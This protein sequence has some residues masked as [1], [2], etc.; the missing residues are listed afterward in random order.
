MAATFAFTRDTVDDFMVVLFGKRVSGI[1]FLNEFVV[2][3]G[4]YTIGALESLQV[5]Q[6]SLTN[7][8]KRDW[9]VLSASITVQKMKYESA[10]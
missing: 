7:L 8:F 3:S 10:T 6:M 9:L 4:R 5:P 1:V 2:L